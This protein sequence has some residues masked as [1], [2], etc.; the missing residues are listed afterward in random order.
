MEGLY[1]FDE[2]G[3]NLGLDAHDAQHP[4][5]IGPGYVTA[6]LPAAGS[7][8]WVGVGGSGL[9]L[10]DAATGR[11][12]GHRHD[13]AAPDS[14]SGDYVSVLAD[15]APGHLWVGTR[16]N[17][18]NHCRIEPWS[19]ERFDGRS[20]G[21]RNLG[22]YHV[23]ALR[24]DGSG[25]LWVATHGGG[26]H[27]ARTGADG[28]L[29]RFERWG[30]ERGLPHEGI[31]SLE[32]DD[33]GTL[34]IS[35]LHGLTRLDPATGRT[36]HHVVQ[37]G[38][39]AGRFNAG[40]SSSDDEF[41][42]FGALEGLVAVP[43]GTALRTRTA[44]P[45]RVT[46]IERLTRGVGRPLPPSALA[47]GFDVDF[48]D[49][50]VLEFA[51]LDFAEAPHEYAYRLG[52]YEDWIALGRRRQV[53]FV[54]LAPG[55]YRFEVQGRDLF[56]QWSTSLPLE[57][58]VVPPVWMTPW[59]RALAAALV[60]LLVLGVHRARLRS[61][62]RRNARLERLKRQREQALERAGHSQRELEEAYAGLRQLTGRLES[63]KE[64]ERSRI[65]RE[66]HDEFGQTLTAAK[67]NLQLLRR[68]A[69]E[70]TVAQ[71][72]DDSVAMVDGMIRQARDIARGLRPPLL[73]EAGLV[74]ALDHHLKALAE[75][76][77][78]D[79]ELDAPAGLAAI[80]PGHSMIVFRVVQ[81]AVSNALRHAR[82]RTIRVRLRAVPDALRLVVEDDGV[83]FDPLAVGQS[84]RRGEHLGLLG[85]TERVRGAGGTIRLDSRPGEGSRIEVSLPLVRPAGS[86][87]AAAR[88][89]AAP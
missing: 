6:L 47:G 77:G 78:V 27:R 71:R 48:D 82:A 14:L 75:R 54:G 13:A 70:P 86:G 25:A 55:R 34:W 45:V 24:R 39:P 36:T 49:V 18:L 17:G 81:E 46:A 89:G 42:Y 57:F 19:C 41:I 37:S 5:G 58:A 32:P 26:L 10:R 38:L 40:A 56:G 73:D 67:I 88:D 35:T 3:R 50:L 22:H 53:T 51:V 7:D 65:S 63:A 68:T 4:D 1:R 8:L 69:A 44:H 23:T 31:L 20:A 66:L 43:R 59:F 87:G 85:M 72:L 9:F 60:V 11:Y 62:R 83:G 28:R 15:G 30:V 29:E 33:D 84:A 52:P 2:D 80:A 61:L 16:S 76:S 21:E 74:P 64:D 79:I 12:R